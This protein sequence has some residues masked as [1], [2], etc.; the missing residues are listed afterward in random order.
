MKTSW[1]S[2]LALA[3]G[4]GA[5][6]A[7]DGAGDDVGGGADAGSTTPEC[8]SSSECPVGWTCN[9]FGFC[10]A[11]SD[12]GG[13]GGVPPPEVE[14]EYGPP[15][16]SRRYVWVAMTDQD[17]VAR[18][19]GETLEVRSIAVGDQPEMLVAMP[20]TD[21]AVVLDATNG[22]VTVVS[23]TSGGE[24]TEV[25][26]ALPNLH[27]LA[28]SPSGVHAVAYFDLLRAI[29]EAGSLEEIDQVGSFQD[30]TV[31]GLGAG[32][33]ATTVDLTVGFRPREIEFDAAGDRA[34]VVTDDGISVLDLAAVLAEGP[35]IVPPVPITPDPF[36]DT[37]AFEVDVVSSGELAV[38]REAGGAWLR[39][40]RLAAPD[41]GAIAELELPGVPSDLELSPDG[42]RA[43]A[44]LREQG[45]LAVV[46]LPEDV[47]DPSGIE[48]VDLSAATLGSLTLTADGRR[49]VLYT[50]ATLDER[51][52]I[53]ELAEPGLPHRTFPLQKSVRAIGL[54][55]GG[56]KILVIHARA[57]GDPDD[58]ETFDEYIDRSWGYS[59]V[60]VATGFAKLE[61][62]EVD[63][64][65]FSFSTAAPR[66][67]LL[68]DGGDTEGALAEVQEIELDTGVVRPRQ[69]GSP[70]DAV[71]VLPDSGRVFVSQRHP[72]GR[73]TFI[74]VASGEARTVTGFDLNSQTID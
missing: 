35:S 49:G 6:E 63:P 10:V 43:Y 58:A 29:A 41:L 32:G 66:A 8:F 37:S 52:T 30:V 54:D 15:V 24:I 46:D 48:L 67:Y 56:A 68:L 14:Y 69:L 51:L 42:R 64:G 65:G 71:G 21:T 44:V 23:P 25:E 34:Y 28:A 60:D 31:V 18:I 16:S 57:P 55:P 26:P 7:A 33:A 50:N 2:I 62:T 12:P 1:M 74:E 5:G 53:I 22:A 27:V 73:V 72:L 59:V 3:A 36:E 19:D 39:V 9:E 11:P 70:P 20:G 45:A 40:V 61:I 13:D 17:A 38:V 47:V 4:C